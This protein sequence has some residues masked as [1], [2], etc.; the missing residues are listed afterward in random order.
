MIAFAT[1]AQVQRPAPLAEL[2]FEYEPGR[3]WVKGTLNGKPAHTMLDSG[4]GGIVVSE[5]AAERAGGSKAASIQADTVGGPSTLW[6]A[7]G[8]SFGLEA[9]PVTVAADVIAS[10]AKTARGD[11]IDVAAGFSLFA[12]LGVQIDYVHSKVRLYGPGQYVPAPGETA[13][14]IKFVDRTPRVTMTLQMPDGKRR[15]VV[16]LVDTGSPVG[17][18]ITRRYAKRDGMDKRYRDLPVVDQPGGVGGATQA[19]TV[20]GIEG[21]FG[22]TKLDGAATVNMTETGSTGAK[23]DY[24]VLLGDGVLRHF[25]VTFDYLRATLWVRPNGK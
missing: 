12:G 13:L 24:D 18:E 17:L 2:S 21:E 22:G 9:G 14:P 19:R 8:M 4:A 23:A 25:D 20:P 7:S 10:F 6:Y 5:E 16:A 1:L 3:I 15:K 11:Q